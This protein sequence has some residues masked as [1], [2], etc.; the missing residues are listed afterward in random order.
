MVRGTDNVQGTVYE[1]NFAHS[2]GFCGYYPSSILQRVRKN[3]YKQ[4]TAAGVGCFVF[5]SLERL[6]EQTILSLLQ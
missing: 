5:Y 1:D 4:G 3:V 6:N 2:R